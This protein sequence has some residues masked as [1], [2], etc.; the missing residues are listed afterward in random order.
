MENAVVE[1]ARAQWR[2]GISVMEAVL[3]DPSLLAQL[4][5]AAQSTAE[6]LR[7]GRKLLIAGNGGSAADAQHMAAEFVSR[8]CTDRPPMRALALTVDSSILTAIGND[9]GFEH[10]F[11]RQIEALGCQGDV[12][13][14][15]STS[16]NSPNVL[17]ALQAARAQG[18]IT[19]GLTGRGGGRMAALCDHLLAVPSPVTMYVQQAHLAMEHLFCLLV[20]KEYFGETVAAASIAATERD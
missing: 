12:F 6:A 14:A 17:L 20:E 15:I 18:M 7:S 1:L 8:L 11:A 5:Q 13:A 16:G 2:R 9:Y 4:A 3:A 19:I 10:S